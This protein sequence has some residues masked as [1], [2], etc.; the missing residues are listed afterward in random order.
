MS[1]RRGWVYYSLSLSAALLGY[2]AAPIIARLPLSIT[3]YYAVYLAF[4]ASATLAPTLI[5]GRRLGLQLAARPSRTSTLQALAAVAGAA[6]GFYAFGLV[7]GLGHAGAVRSLG[8]FLL[9]AAIYAM[10]ALPAAVAVRLIPRGSLEAPA[11]ILVGLA[12]LNPATMLGGHQGYAG[13]LSYTII[14]LTLGLALLSLS[15][16]SGPLASWALAVAYLVAATGTPL[17]LG[18]GLP[19]FL[20]ASL[21]SIYTGCTAALLASGA[22][23]ASG[24]ALAGVGNS[25]GPPKTPPPRPRSPGRH[26]RSLWAAVAL[27]S[28]L[29]VAVL[30]LASQGV[31]VW[32]PMVIV[33]G[34]MRGTLNPG[35]VVLLKRPD[36]LS[37][38]D[39][40][41][42]RVGGA[43]VTHRIAG[44]VAP[45]VYQ[46]KGD[47]N[48]EP[49]P[50]TVRRSEII[51]VV[52]GRLP[53]VG[54]PLILLNW[55][56]IV[57][58]SAVLAASLA[59]ALLLA[60]PSRRG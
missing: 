53:F 52:W 19:A 35:D 28:G 21:A 27:A 51:G 7:F 4:L 41:T 3:A 42:Y 14:A 31:M 54:W 17:T 45:G 26:Q 57:R 36:S 49:D 13:M 12:L 29:T 11:A 22:R 2:L 46:T 50:Y 48:P 59:A 40:V 43:V 47:A 60:L 24:A 5:I 55:N 9:D 25:R 15:R 18:G 44:E 37:V 38:G 30:A 56:P 6:S 20:T 39:I 58:V 10:V 34:S 23:G 16:L 32:K 8:G 33:T 1:V